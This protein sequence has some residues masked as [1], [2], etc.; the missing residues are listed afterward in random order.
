MREYLIAFGIKLCWILACFLVF[1]IPALF[2]LE[3]GLVANLIIGAASV[4]LGLILDKL[5]DV[6]FPR[7]DH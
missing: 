1:N 6:S 7:S 2:G 5:F 4:I 3:Y